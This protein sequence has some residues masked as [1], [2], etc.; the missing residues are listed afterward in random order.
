L[1]NETSPARPWR[2]PMW[3]HGLIGLVL[4]LIGL[5][6][7]RV[8][9]SFRYARTEV[10]EGEVWRLLTGHLVHLSAQ[11]LL[12]NLAGLA[13][14]A[15]LFARAYSVRQWLMI[16]LGTIIVIDLGFV[17]CEPQ[18]M[19]YVG[20]S[21][22]LHGALA[23][24]AIAWWRRREAAF[25]LVLSAALVVKLGWEQWGGAEPW[26]AAFPVVVD[27]HLYGALGGLLVAS[28]LWARRQP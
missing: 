18:L 9:E 28:I 23:A 3:L 20:Y 17:F 19:W 10:L 2:D 5:F 14:V 26:S 27:A 11:H 6:G 16:L 15:A 12:L 25:A 8:L 24:G 1:S 22:V 7:K 4:V 13:L 21:G